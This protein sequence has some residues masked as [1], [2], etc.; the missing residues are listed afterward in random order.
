MPYRRQAE[1]VLARWRDAERK[2]A[3]AIPGTPDEVA[4]TVE[5]ARYRA[6]Y[7]DLIEAARLAHRPEPP[8]LDELLRRP[9]REP[10][11]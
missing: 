9:R 8:A 4:L 11:R 6:E 5:I 10:T 7:Q 2:L 1:I 3:S